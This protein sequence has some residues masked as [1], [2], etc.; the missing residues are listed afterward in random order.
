MIGPAPAARARSRVFRP[1]DAQPNAAGRRVVADPLYPWSWRDLHRRYAAALLRRRF[2]DAARQPQIRKLE[3]ER[4]SR[5]ILLIHR[6]E[7]MSLLGLPL[8]HYIDVH[9]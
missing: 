6:Q 5:V 7:T 4:M 9:D 3:R 8:P 2:L 1:H